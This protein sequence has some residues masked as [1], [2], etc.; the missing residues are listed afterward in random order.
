MTTSTFPHCHIT[1]L[2]VDY[3][4]WDA[5]QQTVYRHQSVCHALTLLS[6][7]RVVEL[8]RAMSKHG[9]HAVVHQHIN[10]SVDEWRHRLECA[11]LC[12]VVIR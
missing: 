8:K 11:S 6:S 1:V 2:T 3:A 12:T 10:K 4:V 5:L 9:R 7:V